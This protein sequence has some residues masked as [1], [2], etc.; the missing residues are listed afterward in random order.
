MPGFAPLQVQIKVVFGRFGYG[1]DHG[2]SGR[3]AERRSGRVADACRVRLLGA[4]HTAYELSVSEGGAVAL[5][6]EGQRH[7]P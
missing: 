6:G 4:V 1:M 3:W 2:H 7:C 5:L